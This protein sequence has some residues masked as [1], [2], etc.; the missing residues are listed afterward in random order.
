MEVQ[1]YGVFATA[2]GGFEWLASRF[3]RFTSLL[4]SEYWLGGLQ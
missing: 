1:I 3:A 2:L 4:S